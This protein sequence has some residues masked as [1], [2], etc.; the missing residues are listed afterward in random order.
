MMEKKYVV[1]IDV[2]GQSVKM[3]VVD[4]DAT[5]LARTRFDVSVYGADELRGFSVTSADISVNLR[6]ELA[7]IPSSVSAS[8]PLTETIMTGP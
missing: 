6:Q 5:I 1:G 3:G 2:G 4:R 8:V 7:L